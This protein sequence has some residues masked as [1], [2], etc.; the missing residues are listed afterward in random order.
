MPPLSRSDSRKRCSFL[1]VRGTPASQI[2]D[3]RRLTLGGKLGHYFSDARFQWSNHTGFLEALK[4]D[5]NAVRNKI[6]HHGHLATLEEALTANTAANDFF[7]NG[8]V[9]QH[10]RS[11][12]S[13]M[14]DAT[15]ALDRSWR[16]GLGAERQP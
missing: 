16:S 14:K 9:D 10:H 2:S 4:Q 1:E 7:E 8:S 5:I 11:D 6:L 15:A 3:Y 12:E 13:D